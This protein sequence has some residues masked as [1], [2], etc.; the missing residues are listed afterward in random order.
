MRTWNLIK[1]RQA[2]ATNLLP[3]LKY[4]AKNIS[5]IQWNPS[6]DKYL[7]GNNQQIDVYTV[8]TAGLYSE[9]TFDSKVICV[10]FLDDN[11]I[12]VGFEDGQ[13]KFCDTRI[14]KPTLEMAAHDMRVKCIANINDLLVSASSSGE[15]K[16]WKYSKHSLNMLQKVDCGARITCLTLALSYKNF[17][18]SKQEDLEEERK[19]ERKSILR[20]KQEVIIEDE[21][22]KETE[23]IPICKVKAKH[24]KKR[25]IEDLEDNVQDSKKK[26][27]KSRETDVTKKK[28]KRNR[29]FEKD[30]DANDKSRK[31]MLKVNESKVSS[32]K[33]KKD[34][35][36]SQSTSPTKK[37]KNTDAMKQS[38]VA[39]LKHKG[40][41]PMTV[42]AEDAPPRKKKKK[43]VNSSKEETVQ[44]KKRKE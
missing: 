18:Q 1:G 8:E 23:D 32:R 39:Y 19:I 31:K 36:I 3:R 43:K 35:T 20:L 26:V 6:G 30:E 34:N 11:L 21:G 17:A 10:D 37:I 15:I 22:E 38:S 4:D 27:L 24:K 33:R 41:L 25:V 12:A 44:K 7:L 42:D 40:K 29:S 5:I 13:I 14:S 9:L 28:R 2:Y 16:L